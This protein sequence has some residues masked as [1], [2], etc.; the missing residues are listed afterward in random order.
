MDVAQVARAGLGP[1]AHVDTFCRDSLPPPEQWPDLLFAC[2]S[3]T[4]RQRLNCAEALLDGHRPAD[5]RCL[6]GPGVDVD[7]RRAAGARRTRIAAVLSRGARPG[8][9]QPGAAARP[10]QPLAGRLLARGAEGRRRSRWRRCPRSAPGELR[11]DRRDHPPGARA[12]RRPVHRRPRRRPYPGCGSCTTAGTAPR[13]SAPRAAGTGRRSARVA[14]AADDV[15]LLAFTSGTTGRAEGDHALPPGR[16]RR[17]PTRS[18]AHVLQADAPTICSSAAR[19]WPSPSG[20][21]AGGLPAAG[22]RLDAAGRDGRRPDELAGVVAEHG[23]TVLLHRARP[24]T[25]RCSR[26]AGAERLRG[27]RRCVSAGEHAAAVDLGRLPRRDRA[28]DHR[29][30]R[31]HRDAAH[32]H[33]RRRRRHPPRVDRPAGARATRPRSSTTT[34]EPGAGREPGRLAVRGPTGCRYLADPRQRDYV[35]HGWNITGDTYRPRRRR[36]LLV[37]RPQRRHDHLGRVQHR[38]SRG[39]GRAARRHPDVVECGVVGRARPGARPGRHRVRRAA[40]RAS[41]ATPPRPPSCR[42]CVKQ[43]I[44]PYKCPRA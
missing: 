29:R 30:H 41:P 42:S 14:T 33:L 5:R 40:R 7:V 17:S 8:A 6:L 25:G 39:G 32:L 44:A 36:L 20:S 4:T 15:A 9:G 27:L 13:T 10:E 34:A 22:R 21:A 28:A 16:A 1:S 26:R 3:C 12:L 38:R 31:L 18:R 37:R 2:R 11:V 35:Q 43:E 24:R 19:R 23:V